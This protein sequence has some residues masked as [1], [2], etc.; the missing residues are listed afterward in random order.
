[1][2]INNGNKLAL[3]K[4]KLMYIMKIMNLPLTNNEIT[5]LVLEKNYMDYFTLQQILSE[6]CSSNFIELRP[7]NGSEYYYLADA[8]KATLEMFSDKLPSSF[9]EEVNIIYTTEK[10]EIK[11]HHELLG[12]YF[13]RAANEFIVNL[14]VMENNSIIFSMSIS[15]PTE[16]QAKLICEKW[17]SN[18]DKIYGKIIDLLISD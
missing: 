9:K 17:N 8:G 16:Q 5:K 3:F 1:M 14:Q 11:K 10:K 13:K 18:P 15:V 12:H 6:L 2:V 4:L 7:Q